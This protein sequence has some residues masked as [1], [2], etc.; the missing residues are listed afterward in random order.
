MSFGSQV[1]LSLEAH[2]VVPVHLD[3]PSLV[4]YGG[5]ENPERLDGLRFA[6]P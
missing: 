3:F 6:I 2:F 1:D 4:F 5:W